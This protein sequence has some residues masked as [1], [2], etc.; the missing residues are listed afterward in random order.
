[1]L[2]TE[3]EIADLTGYVQAAAQI[4][5]LR[6]NG[7]THFIRADGKPRVPK[8]VLEASGS[9]AMAQTV[10]PNFAAIRRKG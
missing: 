9:A 4:R 10:E 1:M 3:H 7:L 5:W 6:K 2:L 8:S